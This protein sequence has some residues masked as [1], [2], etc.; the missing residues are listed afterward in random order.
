MATIPNYW[1]IQASAP[2][3]PSWKHF[4]ELQQTQSGDVVYK[5]SSHPHIKGEAQGK[6]ACSLLLHASI[7]CTNISTVGSQSVRGVQSDQPTQQSGEIRILTVYNQDKEGYNVG[8]NKL[9]SIWLK[10]SNLIWSL[11]NKREYHLYH[12]QLDYC[13][14]HFK[15]C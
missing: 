15:L 13:L 5:H 12:W 4:R 8:I 11:K 1:C 3:N 7:S 14:I 10:H 9:S 6:G 2:K